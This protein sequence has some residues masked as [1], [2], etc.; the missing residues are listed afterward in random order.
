MFGILEYC[1]KKRDLT[2]P[3]SSSVGL[4]TAHSSR[5]QVKQNPIEFANALALSEQSWKRFVLENTPA[6]TTFGQNVLTKAS[7]TLQKI[8]PIS[9]FF[10]SSNLLERIY[11]ATAAMISE[12][13]KREQPLMQIDFERQS[14]HAPLF[15][16]SSSKLL[17]EELAISPT[18]SK[19]NLASCALFLGLTLV[20]LAGAYKYLKNLKQGQINRKEVEFE[21]F[22]IAIQTS[23]AQETTKTAPD[24][25]R[26]CPASIENISA[27]TYQRSDDE[28]L[29]KKNYMNKLY[30]WMTFLIE[31]IICLLGLPSYKK[32]STT[33]L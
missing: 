26:S 13:Q 2:R 22:K 25:L 3:Q 6:K 18:A 33:S 27:K 16:N 10:R 31:K 12:Q 5:I 24:R 1:F 21:K 9:I 8:L 19:A 14:S 11:E 23:L 20:V 4:L 15:S 7:S 29:S 32:N 17:V 30:V 28:K